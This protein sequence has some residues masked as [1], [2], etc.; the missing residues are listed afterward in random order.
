[1]WR[2]IE[3]FVLKNQMLLRTWYEDVM[4][5]LGPILVPV[6]WLCLLTSVA[7]CLVWMFHLPTAGKAIGVLGGVGVVVA[8]CGERLP[9]GHR[10]P[11]AIIT[12]ILL[13]TE[14][15]AIDNDHREQ[16]DAHLKELRE[17]LGKMNDLAEKGEKAIELSTEAVGQITGGDTWIEIIPDRGRGQPFTS[18][19]VV[20]HGKYPF[21]GES[22]EVYDVSGLHRRRPTFPP[23][24]PDSLIAEAPLRTYYPGSAHALVLSVPLTNERAQAFEFRIVGRTGMIEQLV[25][26]S[27]SREDWRFSSEVHRGNVLLRRWADPKFPKDWKLEPPPPVDPKLYPPTKNPN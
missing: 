17:T 8:L 27:R 10:V 22:V 25:N 9:Q 2:R 24:A 4:Q 5:K 11:W 21:Y 6:Y 23:P 18:F 26:F 1:M 19:G 7:V 14:V 12:V 20:V 3:L 13:V 15:R 16:N